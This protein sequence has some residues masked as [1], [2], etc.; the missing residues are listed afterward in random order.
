MP[1]TTVDIDAPILKELKRRQA[2]EGQ[3]LGRLISDLLARALAEDR[4]PRMPKPPF[5][6]IARDMGI[7]VDLTD[8]DALYELLDDRTPASR[9]R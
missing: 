9:R 1:R 2:R 8:K 7:R 3:S 5:Q 4:G 6:W